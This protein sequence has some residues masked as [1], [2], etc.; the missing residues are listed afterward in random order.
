MK[1]RTFD[2]WKEFLALDDEAKLVGDDLA[3]ELNFLEEWEWGAG[4]DKKHAIIGGAVVLSTISEQFEAYVT[5]NHATDVPVIKAILF[6]DSATSY[7][8]DFDLRE[9]LLAWADHDNASVED[10]QKLRAMCVEVIALLDA[11]EAEVD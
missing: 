5:F 11:K 1:Q 2:E 8:K 10:L 3:E 7:M 4:V 9:A 6:G